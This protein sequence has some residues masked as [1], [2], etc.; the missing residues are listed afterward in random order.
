[1]SPPLSRYPTPI[2]VSVGD[3]MTHHLLPGASWPPS[4]SVLLVPGCSQ[5][6]GPPMSNS[7][8]KP[9]HSIF[10]RS[11]VS[12][13]AASFPRWPLNWHWPRSRSQGEA[14][15]VQAPPGH[16]V[17]GPEQPSLPCRTASLLPD[18][19]ITLAADFRWADALL[20]LDY[21]G[22][23]REMHFTD[24]LPCR[25]YCPSPTTHTLTHTHG[26]QAQ[27]STY[28]LTGR[29]AQLSS[30]DTHRPQ[31]RSTRTPSPA[32]STPSKLCSHVRLPRSLHWPH[33]T[34]RADTPLSE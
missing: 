33:D 14:V 12:A 4:T 18:T 11:P 22:Y 9:A 26:S 27:A 34:S 19:S 5:E 31:R 2:S 21:L 20:A 17:Q 25:A 28:E 1:M 10:P 32:S 7:A 24:V 16:P 30:D 15:R 23:R 6:M 8:P 29:G 3:Q 13:A